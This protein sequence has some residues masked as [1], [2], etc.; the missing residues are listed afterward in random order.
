MLKKKI[1]ENISRC[2]KTLVL[3]NINELNENFQ[4]GKCKKFKI[5]VLK[6]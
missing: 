5:E 4:L 2:T 3:N 6:K 1:L